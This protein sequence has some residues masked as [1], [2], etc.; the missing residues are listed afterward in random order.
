MWF[1]GGHLEWEG[2]DMADEQPAAPAAPSG[3]RMV[4]LAAAVVLCLAAGGALYWSIVQNTGTPRREGA[5]GPGGGMPGGPGGRGGMGGGRGGPPALQ[6]V[7]AEVLAG[8]P[9][10]FALDVKPIFEAA[11][12]RCHRAGGG[13]RGGPGAGPATA[14]TADAGG[15]P[16]RPG[17]PPGARGGNRGPGGGLRLDDAAAAAMSGGK[18]GPAL[19]PGQP[20]ESLLYQLLKGPVTTA[21]GDEIAAMPSPGPGR[22]FTPLSDDRIAVIRRWIADGAKWDA[23][24]P[25]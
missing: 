22:D 24:Q 19:V 6:P 20:D 7:R 11:C 9:V 13:N 25:E 15:P 16:A 1:G 17:G 10:D 4:K 12:I 18:H 21:D 8:G 14:A 2:F 23:A 5:G 3:N